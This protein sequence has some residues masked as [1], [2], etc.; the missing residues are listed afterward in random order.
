MVRKRI[1]KTFI[2]ENLA[3]TGIWEDTWKADDNYK[4]YYIYVIR[5][6][7]LAWTKSL[8]TL[9]IE[10]EAITS[11]NVPVSLLGV[12]MFT[13]LPIGEEIKK[14]QEFKWS[15][16]NQEGATIDVFL[17]LDIERM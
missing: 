15:L 9:W 12:D 7:A 14:E 8:V 6:D 1:L 13:A 4:I 10:D 3:D 16:K 11:E 2:K 17:V 5:G